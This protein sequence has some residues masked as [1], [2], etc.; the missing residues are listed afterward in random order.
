MTERSFKLSDGHSKVLVKFHWVEF[1]LLDCGVEPSRL[2]SAFTCKS[3]G[4]E[5]GCSLHALK[6]KLLG[7]HTFKNDIFISFV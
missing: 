1:E 5:G 4:V 6:T 2:V 7:R 3:C